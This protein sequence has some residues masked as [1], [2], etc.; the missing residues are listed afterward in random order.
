MSC[1]Y[2]VH[3]SSIFPGSRFALMEVKS[4]LFYLLKKFDI[5]E[6]SKTVNPLIL[7]PKEIKMAPKNGFWVGLRHRL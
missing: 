1:H 2:P 7:D 5:V 6:V 3:V 4:V